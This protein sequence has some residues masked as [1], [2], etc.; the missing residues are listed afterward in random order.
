MEIIFEVLFQFLFEF[1]LQIVFEGLVEVGLHGLADV[2]KSEKDRNPVLSFIGYLILGLITGAASLWVF[3]HS[4]IRS[5]RLHGISLIITPLL[6]G[7]L[8]S[9]IG[10]LRER[11]GKAIIR[12]DT[13]SFGFIFAFGMAVVRLVYTK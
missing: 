5:S 1:L 6:A 9:A 13:F 7:L 10:N 2:F 3:P 11:K 12:L 8:M 4:F